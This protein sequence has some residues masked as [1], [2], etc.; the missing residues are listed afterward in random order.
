MDKETRKTILQKAKKYKKWTEGMMVNPIYWEEKGNPYYVVVY[1]RRKTPIASGF[2][3]PGEENVEDAMKAHRPLALF[4]DLGSNVYQN[5]TMRSSVKL[6]FYTQPLD[7]LVDSRD[8]K[9]QAGKAAYAK[10]LKLQEEINEFMAEYKD[11][12][13]NDVLKRR[14]ITEKDV[15]KV[16]KAAVSLDMFQYRSGSVLLKHH[17]DIEAF[18]AYLETQNGWKSLD[19]DTRAF[20]KD[21][22][23]HMEEV[24][25]AFDAMDFIEHENPEKMFR[26]HYDRMVKNNKAA[27]E[28]QK[29]NIRYPKW[30]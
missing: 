14:L 20:L 18:A 22:T 28:Q 29:E 4:S 19:K 7:L 26:L 1:T 8:E 27:L 17:E 3:T 15:E 11:Y 24:K 10:L 21:I 2:F 9:V 5:G 25:K 6:S 23:R 13:E 16:Q 12:Y 30:N